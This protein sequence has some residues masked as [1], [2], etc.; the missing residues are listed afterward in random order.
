MSTGPSPINWYAS[1][2]SPFH[3]NFVSGISMSDHHAAA[4]DDELGP[5]DVGSFVAG[6]EQRRVH[7]VARGCEP[8]EG[9]RGDRGLDPRGVGG[10]HGLHRRGD[11]PG[12]E[13]TLTIAPPPASISFGTPYLQIQT[14]PLTLIANTRSHTASSV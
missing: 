3:A 9:D 11:E 7:H 1:A 10:A 5:G 13:P 8:A 6:Q 4:V 12:G 14:M 2:T